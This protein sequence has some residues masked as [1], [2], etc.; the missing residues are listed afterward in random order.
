[1]VLQL[2]LAVLLQLSHTSTMQQFHLTI[3][4]KTLACTCTMPDVCR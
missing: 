3:Q 1:M 4:V 2:F